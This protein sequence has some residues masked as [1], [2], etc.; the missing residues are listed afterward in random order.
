MSAQLNYC[1]SGNCGSATDVQ[2]CIKQVMGAGGACFDLTNECQ[3]VAPPT[4]DEG[5]EPEPEPEPEPN[6]EQ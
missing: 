5:P 6:P 3:G 4:P 2:A 1:L